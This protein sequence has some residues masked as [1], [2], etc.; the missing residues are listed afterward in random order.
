MKMALSSFVKQHNIK[1]EATKK[2]YYKEYVFKVVLNAP[3]GRIL[4][5]CKK[6][7]S[8][9]DAIEF[10][11]KLYDK[12]L[13]VVI[14]QAA[15][16]NSMSRLRYQIN[17]WQDQIDKLDNIDQDYFERLLSIV[18]NI[19][20]IRFSTSGWS[21]TLFFKTE[22]GIEDAI[23]LLKESDYKKI[24]A[25]FYPDTGTLDLLQEGK[26]ISNTQPEFKYRISIRSGRYSLETRRAISEVFANHADDVKIP[27]RLANFL[28]KEGTFFCYNCYFYC[29]STDILFLINLIDPKFV[30][31]TNEIVNV[32][33]Q[34]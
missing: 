20:N 27:K 17:H 11:R 8:V 6:K 34:Q 25:I 24:D 2:T 4:H 1:S 12:S 5:D 33:V 19:P 14:N 31:T 29:N 13:Q 10:R 3:M 26:I 16:L 18:R 30:G 21:I 15:M 32:T 22:A 9:K 7:G 28:V 23:A